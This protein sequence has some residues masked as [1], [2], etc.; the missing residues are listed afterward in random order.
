MKQQVTINIEDAPKFIAQ[1]VR[2]GVTFES[3]QEVGDV[4]D[5]IVI[6]F[7]GGY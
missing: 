1:L 6:I 4:T 5:V 2:E 7:S 3:Y